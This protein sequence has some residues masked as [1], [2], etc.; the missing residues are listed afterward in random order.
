MFPWISSL[1]WEEVIFIGKESF[2]LTCYSLSNKSITH[3]NNV[4]KSKG[5]K[6]VLQEDKGMERWMLY[7][8]V[9]SSLQKLL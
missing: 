2:F 5:L 3:S 1:F 6:E 7:S 9:E 4:V 8:K